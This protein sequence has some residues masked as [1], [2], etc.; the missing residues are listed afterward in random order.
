M[1]VMD[2]KKK[3][4]TIFNEYGLKYSFIPLAGDR[5]SV[6]VRWG[7]W[8]HDHRRLTAIMNRNKFRELKVD[9]TESDG[10]DCYSAQHI[11]MMM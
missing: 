3:V 2:L 1:D 5:V 10:S 11:Y 6:S 7:D 8:K 4:D 9:V